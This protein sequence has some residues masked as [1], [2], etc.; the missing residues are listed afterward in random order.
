MSIEKAVPQ[1]AFFLKSRAMVD[2][3]ESLHWRTLLHT[4][5]ALLDAGSYVSYNKRISISG[6]IANLACMSVSVQSRYMKEV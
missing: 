4:E 3:F 1:K 5:I 2:V 6:N